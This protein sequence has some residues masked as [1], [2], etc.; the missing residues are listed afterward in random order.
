MK[1]QGN[2]Q[3]K[4]DMDTCMKAFVEQRRAEVEAEKNKPK[5]A[6]VEKPAGSIKIEEGE[7]SD[8]D[9]DAELEKRSRPPRSRPNRLTK[10]L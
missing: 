4:K 8:S 9:D 6:E 5:I 10:K 7:S 3:I 2:N 1:V